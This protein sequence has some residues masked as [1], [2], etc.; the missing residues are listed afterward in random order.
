MLAGPVPEEGR[1]MVRISLKNTFLEL[2]SEGSD[3]EAVEASPS[4]AS[5]LRLRTGLRSRSVEGTP[6]NRRSHS[7]DASPQREEARDRQDSAEAVY[8]QKLEQQLVSLNRLLGSPPSCQQAQEREPLQFFPEEGA[9]ASPPR[10]SC[11]QDRLTSASGSDFCASPRAASGAWSPDDGRSE[12]CST[13]SANASTGTPLKDPAE[14]HE[15]LAP[16]TKIKDY[17]HKQVPRTHDLKGKFELND[18]GQARTTLMI[19]NIP[20][21]LTQSDLISELEN[22]GFDGTYDFLYVPQDHGTQSHRHHGPSK[23]EVSNVGYAFVNFVEAEWADRCEAV[24]QDRV[25]PGSTRSSRVSTAHVQGLEANLAHYKRAAVKNDRLK[26]C[27]PLV[28]PSISHRLGCL[29]PAPR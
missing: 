3:E 22:L 5:P 15:F 27:R 11:L 1:R 6:L 12:R 21:R 10:A 9:E 14:G 26:E 13:C 17:R 2:H 16:G 24:F 7:R 28:M 23:R 25:Y 18:Q 4:V 8:Q 20:N 19:R 29:P